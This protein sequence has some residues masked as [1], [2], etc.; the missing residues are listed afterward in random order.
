MGQALSLLDSRIRGPPLVA[1]T[2][3][4]I[5]EFNSKELNGI[6]KKQILNII[7]EKKELDQADI[8]IVD[9]VLNRVGVTNGTPEYLVDNDKFNRNENEVAKL[10]LNLIDSLKRNNIKVDSLELDDL[11]DSLAGSDSPS[12]LNDALLSGREFRVNQIV[13]REFGIELP[14]I[15]TNEDL[16]SRVLNFFA[17]LPCVFQIAKSYGLLQDENVEKELRNNLGIIADSKFFSLL[18]LIERYYSSYDLNLAKEYSDLKPRFQTAIARLKD[19]HPDLV[20]E[21]QFHTVV[22]EVL[23]IVQKLTHL[24]I[25]IVS[26]LGGDLSADLISRLMRGDKLR[27][28]V[29][30]RAILRAIPQK[31]EKLL[32]IIYTLIDIVLSLVRLLL[33]LIV[34][35]FGFLMVALLL[36]LSFAYDWYYG[37]HTTEEFYNKS[38][39]FRQIIVDTVNE[40]PILGP[41]PND[42]PLR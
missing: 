35:I 4:E 16:P 17:H 28:E 7:S 31:H 33:Q 10:L 30:L 27:G 19:I 9:T 36:M 41:I 26:V 40:I 20:E 32:E 14:S 21:L 25:S 1:Q 8:Q 13:R 6:R 3:N 39:R 42:D 11:L 18:P 37:T 34:N 23:F 2:I 22:G 5:Q 24:L 29:L 38:L 15:L 12:R